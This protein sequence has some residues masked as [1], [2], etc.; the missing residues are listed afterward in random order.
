MEGVSESEFWKWY[1][2]ERRVELVLEA[3]RYWS[4]IRWARIEGA[5]GIPELNHRMHA[6]DINSDGTYE[7]TD[8][9]GFGTDYIFSWPKRMFFPIPED[10]IINNPNIDTNNPGW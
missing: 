4:L 6:I 1:K 7:F 3:D 9:N 5:S 8:N 10:E 2:I